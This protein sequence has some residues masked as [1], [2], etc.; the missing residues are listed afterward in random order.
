M[1]LRVWLN[2]IF[3]TDVKMEMELVGE[4]KLLSD[5]GVLRFAKKNQE[6]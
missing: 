2:T 1:W 6:E 4:E 5:S 3:E